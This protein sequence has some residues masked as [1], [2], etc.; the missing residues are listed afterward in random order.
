M[1]RLRLLVVAGLVAIALPLGLT[2]AHA[3]GSTGGTTTNSVSIVSPAQYNLDGTYVTVQLYVRC[4]KGALPTG[5]VDVTVKQSY[6]ETPYP[7]GAYG[8]GF[9]NVVCDGTTRAV[10]VTV[11]LGLFDAGKAY[12]EAVL[13]PVSGGSVKT[14]RWITIVANG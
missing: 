14:S 12:A 5:I 8:T 11:P 13:T 2:A 7:Q 9:T 1:K 6:P 4:K 10:G 3:T